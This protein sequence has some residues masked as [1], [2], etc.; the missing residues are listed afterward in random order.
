MKTID[1]SGPQGNA[2]YLLGLA[3]KLGKELDK[4]SEE[5][6]QIQERM[7]SGD[8][9]NLVAVFEEEFGDLVTL[10]W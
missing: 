10:E 5:R 4:S 9:S 7:T 6:R 1:L 8:Y 2:F 3:D